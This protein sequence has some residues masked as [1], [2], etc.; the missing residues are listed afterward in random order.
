MRNKVVGEV[1]ALPYKFWG[2]FRH[3]GVIFD[4]NYGNAR[5][6]AL[7]SAWREQALL[8]GVAFGNRFRTSAE[9][10]KGAALDRARLWRFS[11]ENGGVQPPRQS[12]RLPQGNHNFLKK[13][14]QN[15]F[16]AAV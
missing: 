1:D 14:D 9:G 11:L 3:I 13:F 6:R 4:N 5:G 12:R 10:G 15:F 8:A 2:S 16:V 7:R